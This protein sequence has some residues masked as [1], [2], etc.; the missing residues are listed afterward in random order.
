M[1]VSFGYASTRNRTRLLHLNLADV[2]FVDAGVDLHLL[3]VLRDH[4]ERRRLHARRN[5]LADVHVARDDD[6]VD[7]RADDRVAEVHLRLIERSLRLHELRLGGFHRRV[8]GVGRRFGRIEIAFGD[9]FLRGEIAGATELDPGV[10]GLHTRALD[11]GLRS[12]TVARS[13]AT[14]VS[15]SDGSSSRDDWPLPD[16]RVEVGAERLDGARHLRADLDGRH[17]LERTGG[18]N[19]CDDVALADLGSVQRRRHGRDIAA[20]VINACGDRRNDRGRCS[21]RDV[22]SSCFL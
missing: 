11:V 4:E 8:R 18:L 21:A 6:A 14:W 3:Q 10:G 19:G 7:R 16:L 1:N 15:N 13:C 12:A 22:C 2:G 9:E 5:G 20:V 17:G